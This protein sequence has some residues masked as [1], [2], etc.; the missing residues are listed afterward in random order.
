M[1]KVEV[2]RGVIKDYQDYQAD[3]AASCTNGLLIGYQ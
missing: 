1:W 3:K 2:R